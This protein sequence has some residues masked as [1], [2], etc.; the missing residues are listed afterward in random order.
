[1]S[2]LE[3]VSKVATEAVGA[4]KASPMMLGLVLLQFATLAAILY[5]AMDRQKAVTTQIAALH[6]LLD[7]CIGGN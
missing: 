2:P 4:L 5:L 7:R 6:Q 1:M 3:E